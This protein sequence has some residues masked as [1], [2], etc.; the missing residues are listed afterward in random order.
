LLAQLLHEHQV[1]FVNRALQAGY[2]YRDMAA[3]E[4]PS[5]AA[6][7]ELSTT[8]VRYLLFADEA[9]LVPNMI[10]ESHYAADFTAAGKRDSAGRSL[11]DLDG[12]TCLLK[13]RCSYMIYSPAFSGLPTPLRQRVLRDLAAELGN[14]TAESH[15]PV[16]ERSA[17]RQILVET[18]PE[19]GEAAH[20]P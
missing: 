7:A 15:L 5:E 19:F 11:R 2:R 20:A 13:H 17:I 14:T 12:Q 9:P 8:L 6:V 4:P 16:P 10:G 18:L 3:A 1:G